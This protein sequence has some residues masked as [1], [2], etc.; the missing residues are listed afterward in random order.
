MWVIEHVPIDI[1]KMV[2]IQSLRAIAI[3]KSKTQNSIFNQNRIRYLMQH[4][5]NRKKTKK[6]KYFRKKYGVKQNH[7]LANLG[8]FSYS[9]VTPMSENV[10][11]VFRALLHSRISYFSQI[12]NRT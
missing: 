3:S 2:F 12:G 9:S 8:Q 10:H 6:I 5:L 1:M 11:I 4:K 7:H